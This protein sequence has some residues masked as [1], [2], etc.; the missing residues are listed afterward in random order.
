MNT[1]VGRNLQLRVSTPVQGR[2]AVL[3]DLDGVLIDSSAAITGCLNRAL[4]EHG[5]PSRPATALGRLIGPPIAAVFAELTGAPTESAL[6]SSCVH[7][8]R[9]HYAVASIPETTVMPGMPSVLIELASRYR[10]AVA[11]S[12]ALALAEP[13]LQALR[14][15]AFFEVVTGPD[16]KAHSEG[17]ATTIRAALAVLRPDQAVMVGDRAFDISGAHL[18]GIPAI[19]V[20]WGNGSED[21]LRSAGAEVIASSPERLPAAVSGLLSDAPALEAE[22]RG[23][24][25]APAT[26]PADPR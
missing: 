8:F 24:G 18:N 25:T 1:P 21:E 2:A 17:K 26:Q 20:L 4:V 6:V 10:L 19:G 12:K 7:T 23:P 5:F 14:L 22:P 15:R 11:T 3:F 16:L 9:D 13:L